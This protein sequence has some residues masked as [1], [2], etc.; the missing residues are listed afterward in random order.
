MRVS[1][2]IFLV[3]CILSVAYL[4]GE[5]VRSALGC[6]GLFKSENTSAG[7]HVEWLGVA[8]Y[9]AN[10][11]VA[12]YQWDSFAVTLYIPAASAQGYKSFTGAAYAYWGCNRINVGNGNYR[13]GASFM[14]IDQTV[15]VPTDRFV[16]YISP[17]PQRLY[18]MIDGIQY[19]VAAC[20]NQ[21]G[22]IGLFMQPG[23]MSYSF[24]FSMVS[25]F[26]LIYKDEVVLDLVPMRQ[27]DVG[28]FQDAI[29]GT[30]FEVQGEGNF[31][32]GPDL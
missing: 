18:W 9:G 19:P 17:S 30:T 7:I 21:G 25:S 22:D 27:G 31:V 24:A 14:G 8:E 1:K 3:S 26:K 4:F 2:V 29:S 32:I 15:T 10:V 11:V 23:D 16:D 13:S 6:K 5:P 28:Y 20:R 12:G